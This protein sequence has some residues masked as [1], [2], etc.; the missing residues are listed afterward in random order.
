[1]FEYLKGK[2]QYKKPEY[3]AL[4]IN[5]IGYKIFISLKTFE[6]INV[7][8]ETLFYIH[9]YIKEDEF[10]LIGFL[11]ESDRIMFQ[12]LLGV[13]GIG[14]SLA[15]SILSSFSVMEIKKMVIEENSVA[16]KKVPKL[17]EKKSKQMILDLKNKIK[18][19]DVLTLEDGAKPDAGAI[20][21]E[22][23]YLAL[24]SLG[25]SKKEIDKI[26]SKDDLRE[27]K[28]IETAIKFVL[29]KISSKN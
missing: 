6:N 24:E 23:L 27:L 9:N 20:L 29:R 3:I 22:E 13:S 10:K 1:M 28:D 15:L 16:L 5:G 7:E 4:D 8:K 19:L 26:L 21:E 25:Y 2:V 12:M 11:N 18:S 17:G 14:V